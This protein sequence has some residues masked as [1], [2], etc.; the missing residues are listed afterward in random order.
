MVMTNFLQERKSVRDFKKKNITGQDMDKIRAVIDTVGTENKD[1]GITFRLFENG[2]I[3][4]QALQGKAGYSGVMIEA[5]HYISLEM[6]DEEEDT[7]LAGGYALEKLNTGLIEEGWGTCW[8]TVDQVDETTKKEIFGVDGAGV[9]Y[10]VAVGIP[11]GKKLFSPE[12]VSSRLEVRDIVFKDDLNTPAPIEVL[13]NLGLFEIFSSVRY[14]P[15]HK[16]YQPWRFLLKDGKVYML[17]KRGM[18]D[19]RSL[20]DIGVIM[21]YFEEMAKTIGIRNSWKLLDE[22]DMDGLKVVAVYSL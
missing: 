8:I 16:N 14:A 9:D 1:K 21:F 13:E 12:T 18:E 11:K 3:I 2:K 5:P 4:A 15:S 6:A 7:L 17:M 10:L 20:V 19:R 22:P